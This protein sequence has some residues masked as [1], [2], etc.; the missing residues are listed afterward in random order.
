MFVKNTSPK[1]IGFGDIFVT[2]GSLGQLPEGFNQ[3]HPTIK[4]F[5]NQ[6]FLLLADDLAVAGQEPE[7]KEPG[8]EPEDK[9]PGLESDEAA[10]VTSL[11]RMTLE[12]LRSEAEKLNIEFIEA[13]TRADL[14]EKIRAKKQ[15]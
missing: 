6:G 7:D 15:D 4:Y 14:I 8:Q 11:S 10:R 2:P 1:T 3:N 13:D 9:E 12:Q 5:L